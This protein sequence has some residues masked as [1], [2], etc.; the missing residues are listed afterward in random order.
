M[1]RAQSDK[2]VATDKEPLNIEKLTQKLKRIE[3]INNWLVDSPIEH[4]PVCFDHRR[5][6]ADGQPTCTSDPAK[7]DCP[8]V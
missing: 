4:C 5:V 2:Q 6:D 8:M 7:P 1:S 3:G